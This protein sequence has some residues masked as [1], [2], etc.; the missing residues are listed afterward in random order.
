MLMHHQK[1]WGNAW[2]KIAT[3]LPG[4]SSNAVKNR[5]K[6]LNRHKTKKEQKAEVLRARAIEW[7]ICTIWVR[8][9]TELSQCGGWLER[10]LQYDES[11]ASKRFDWK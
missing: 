4:R 3:H 1:R 7:P 2:V 9:D 11:S 8:G 6:W 10:D 5:C